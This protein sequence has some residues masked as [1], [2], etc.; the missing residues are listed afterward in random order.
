MST[1]T[2]E[3]YRTESGSTY[4]VVGRQIR[5]ANADASGLLGSWTPYE[6]IN[7]LPAALFHPGSQ[8][9]ILE[10]VLTTGRR[11]YTSRLLTPW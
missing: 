4:E 3:L 11:I 5:R 6:R 7:R 2:L 8:G 1:A 9:E 10:I